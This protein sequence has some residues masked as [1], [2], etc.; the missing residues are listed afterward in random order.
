MTVFDR[1]ERQRC[2]AEGEAGTLPFLVA[3]DAVR[4]EAK[5]EE[6]RGHDLG[7]P[8]FLFAFTEALMKESHYLTALRES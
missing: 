1:K 5:L 2:R 8:D 3:L 4:Q 7:P 6:S